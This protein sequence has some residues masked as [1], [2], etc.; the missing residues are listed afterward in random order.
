MSIETWKQEFYHV[1]ATANMTDR[2]A[3]EHGIQKWEGF[4]AKNRRKHNVNRTNYTLCDALNE[5]SF[6]IETCALCL[7]YYTGGCLA[8]PLHKQGYSCTYFDSPYD[9]AHNGNP[10]AMIA[11]LKKC[12][13]NIQE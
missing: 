5:F 8:C 6:G 3:I 4:K 1:P 12:L 13:V 11:A 7:K 2:E 9:A 10:A